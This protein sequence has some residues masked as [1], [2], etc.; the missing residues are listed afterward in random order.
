MTPAISPGLSCPDEAVLLA[1]AAGEPLSPELRQHLADCESC[2]DRLEQ[3]KIELELLRA[4][5]A[6]ES[7]ATSTL[8]QPEQNETAEAQVSAA[9]T[10]LGTSTEPHE[11]EATSMPA[12]IGKYLVVGRF[13]RT[14]QAEVYRVVHPGLAR[15]LVLKL[16]TE[17]IGPDGRHE[18]IE[19]GKILAELKHPALVQIYDLDFHDDR[20]YLVMEYVRGQTLEQVAEGRLK[21]HRA[22]A[23]LAKVAGAVDYAHRHGIVHRD[24]KPK[25]ILVDETGEPRL[26]DFGMA[27]LRHAWSDDPGKPGG[28]FAFMPPEQ[29]RIESSEEQQKVG[30]RS[31]VFALGAVLY[32]LLT[33]K[34]PFAGRNIGECWDRA[35]GCDFDRKA[36]DEPKVPRDLR[37]ICL[38]AM[39][40]K[41]ADRFASAGEFQKELHRYVIRPRILASLSGGLILLTCLVLARSWFAIAP[42]GSQGQTVV[43]QQ[44]PASGALAGDLIVRV[45]SRTNANKRDLKIDEPGALPLLPGE[46]VHLEAH[47]NQ[48]AHVYLMWIDG[49]GHASLLYPRDDDKYGAEP[50]RDIA[51]ETVHSP[52]AL[53]EG[54]K[55]TGPG[56]LETVLLLARRTPLLPGTNLVGLIGQLPPSP[57]RN[58]LEVARG[59]FD[60]GQPIEALRLGQHRGIDEEADKIDEPLLQLMER[61]RKEGQFDV[62]RPVRFAYRGE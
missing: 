44:K 37:R 52:A 3:I 23:L 8:A 4:A 15:E 51:R 39:A 27:R 49:Q 30:P 62:I 60:E 17:P 18:I 58:V 7:H 46:Q 25:N 53:D 59:G 35:R 11:P 26:I 31:D 2:R 10:D 50:A 1:A 9:A 40:D 22:A 38:K 6:E 24:I 47:I 56:G 20:P 16:S 5:A 36:L 42:A 61:L 14:G 45:W 32:F 57:L 41:P 28:T 19:E 48:P 43:I 33:T 55:M 29:A 12:A 13:P 54:H 34:A 21:P